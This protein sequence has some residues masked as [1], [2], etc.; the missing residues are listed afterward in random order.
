MSDFNKHVELDARLCILRAIQSESDGRLNESLIDIALQTYGHSRSR[1]WVRNQMRV[2]ADVGAV[3]L[4]EVGT[5]LVAE[6]TRAGVEHLERR[7]IIEGIKRPLPE[8]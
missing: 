6:I 3:M 4:S 8:A 7:K 1:E 5:Y 2:L